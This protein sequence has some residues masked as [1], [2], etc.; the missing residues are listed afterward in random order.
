VEQA[1]SFGEQKLRRGFEIHCIEGEAAMILRN[2]KMPTQSEIKEALS[3]QMRET[4]FESPVLK[5][6]V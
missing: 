1:C 4:L 5:L 6:F 3:W 2:G